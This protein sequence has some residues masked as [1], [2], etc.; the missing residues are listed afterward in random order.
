M[1]RSFDVIIAG[2]GAAGCILAAR[3]SADPA[4]TVLLVE[5]GP[6]FA[7]LEEY[8]PAIKDERFIPPNFLWNY[9]GVRTADDVSPIT[10]IRGKA[11]GG[12]ASVNTMIYQRGA[13]E[14]YDGWGSALWT[15]D[16]LQPFF[17]RIEHDVDFA[18]NG[19]RGIGQLPL[20]RTPRD[21]W[22]PTARAFHDGARELGF[23]T[24]SDLRHN[25][26][27]GVGATPRNCEDGT[28]ISTA[29][30]YLN[31]VRNRPNLIVQGDTSV[32]RVLFDGGRATGIETTRGDEREILHA[33]QV[34]VAGGAIGS[35]H[36]LTL[37]GVGPAEVL[38]RLGIPVVADR[39]GVGRNL[40]DHPAVNVVAR[41]RPGVESGDARI[42]TTLV[43]TADGSDTRND[44]FSTVAS[45]NFSG[46][47]WASHAGESVEVGIACTLNLAESL[48][49]IEVVSQDPSDLPRIHY[50]YLE[51][52]RDRE[53]LR[54]GVRLAVK[55]LESSPFAHLVAERS[56][57]SQEELDSDEALDGWVRGHLR[58]ALHGCG[59]CRMGDAG[60]DRAVVDYHGRV[61][62]VEGLR[63]AD[64][65]I[66]PSVVR[67]P[68]NATAMVIA[69]RVA[70]LFCD[71]QRVRPAAS[72]PTAAAA[73]P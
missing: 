59:T 58:T 2:A 68:T 22:S 73:R 3:L 53:R 52:E 36:M 62:G 16:A 40:G 38:E 35:P 42:L 32:S 34:V 10:V 18:R 11:L 64:L 31:P 54:G 37:S 57:P 43:Y 27:E 6:D 63:V 69:E 61:H 7:T 30:A 26:C 44:M 24:V 49:E 13:P 47:Q 29:I 71:E 70:E 65:S 17:E 60:D 19:R 67:S 8:P 39:P 48:G 41:L 66:T 72:T 12:S 55:I 1:S 23:A 25:V 33:D 5:A 21:E 56:G 45:G 4:R 46:I 14:D 51:S 50:R 28:R 9:Q 20:R 15:N